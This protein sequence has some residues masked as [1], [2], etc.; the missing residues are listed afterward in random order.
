MIAEQEKE[1]EEE[2]IRR[3]S[4]YVGMIRLAAHVP[5]ELRDPWLRIDR[6][7]LADLVTLLHSY[8]SENC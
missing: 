2:V 1:G 5:Y 6:F 3:D 4:C 8:T 7:R